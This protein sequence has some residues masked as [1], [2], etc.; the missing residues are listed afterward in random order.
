VSPQQIIAVLWRYRKQTIIIFLSLLAF[1]VVAIKLL[2]KSYQATATLME[3]RHPRSIGRQGR[4]GLAG[5]YIP[6]E[7]QLM[8]SPKSFCR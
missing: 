5:G 4:D 1:S 6:T 3:T 8:Q 7:I 2:P